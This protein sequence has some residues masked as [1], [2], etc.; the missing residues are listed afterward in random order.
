MRE[1][2]VRWHALSGELFISHFR[3][4]DHLIFLAFAT[5]IRSLWPF[6][7]NQFLSLSMFGASAESEEC[8]SWSTFLYWPLLFVD[9]GSSKTKEAITNPITYK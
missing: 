7:V 6:P 5:I 1:A 9:C 2:L 3:C 4:P 8:I